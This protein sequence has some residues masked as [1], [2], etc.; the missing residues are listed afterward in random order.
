LATIYYVIEEYNI[1]IINRFSTYLNMCAFDED[2]ALP[3]NILQEIHKKK[4]PS[5]QESHDR[6]VKKLLSCTLLLVDI[7]WRIQGYE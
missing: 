7:V 2:E 4:G 5:L 1:E 6:L 3:L